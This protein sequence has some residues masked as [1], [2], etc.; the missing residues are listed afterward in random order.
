MARA[1][2]QPN[3][4]CETF[5][6]PV[7][8]YTPTS[9][10]ATEKPESAF[11]QNPWLLCLAARNGSLGITI[12]VLNYLGETKATGV[13]MTVGAIMLGSGDIVATAKYGTRSGVITHSIGA[14][15]FSVV[16]LGLLWTEG[17]GK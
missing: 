15:L 13:V 2:F 12:L 11:K 14:T 9:K 4:F 8:P 7:N 1:L 10:K 17:V 5:G 3:E 6:L 16:G